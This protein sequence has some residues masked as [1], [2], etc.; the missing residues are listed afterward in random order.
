MQAL[1]AIPVAILAA[2][3]IKIII[4]NKKSTGGSGGSGGSTGEDN[5]GYA[6]T[7]F[8]SA[9][10]ASSLNESN[11]TFQDTSLITSEPENTEDLLS[12]GLHLIGKATTLEL[13]SNVSKVS[14]NQLVRLTVTVK[15][16]QGDLSDNFNLN[17]LLLEIRQGLTESRNV[18]L[19]YL[20][21]GT[22]FAEIS[23]LDTIIVKAIYESGTDLINSNTLTLQL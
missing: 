20:D 13:S 19:K 7:G 4:T 21:I 15:D 3:G 5:G 17:N 16:S 8:T 6:G 18:L 23:V 2:F 22:Y 11:S 12:Q 10:N 1:I 9:F 14:L